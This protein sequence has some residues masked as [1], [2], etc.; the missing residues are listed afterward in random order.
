MATSPFASCYAIS[1]SIAPQEA[2]DL[3]FVKSLLH[4]QPPAEVIFKPFGYSTQEWG[5]VGYGRIDVQGSMTLSRAAWKGFTSRDATA[6]PRD[7]A[8][9]AI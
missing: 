4:V 9:A 3:F 7:A 6:K 1:S 5:D 2:D 8:M